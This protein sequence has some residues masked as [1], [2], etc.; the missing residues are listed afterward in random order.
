MSTRIHIVGAP[1]SGTT[2]LAEL[3]VSAFR[4]DAYAPHEMSI[5]K[6]PDR[7]VD[8]FCSKNP[9]DVLYV[10]PLLAIDRGL[11]V[12]YVLRDPRDAIVS[13]HDKAPDLYWSNLRI[14]K[15]YHRA[16][17]RIM[18]H[19]RC[20]V[21]RYE[22]LVRDPDHVQAE[23]IARLPFLQR[24]H[25]FSD[26]HRIV[27]PSDGSLKALRGVRPIDG[28]NVG[29]WRAHKPRVAAQLQL[30]GPIGDELVALGYEADARWLLELADATP[31]TQA[32][33]HS[34]QPKLARRVRV[35]AQHWVGLLRYVFGVR[36]RVPVLP[37]AHPTSGAD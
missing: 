23:L 4:F 32:S 6:R 21:V 13:R 12:I 26:Y 35:C 9:Q 19:P 28:G 16:A 5:F 15:K 2:L 10:R 17:L 22:D 29:A 30:H 31:D 7:A 14:W 34:E 33:Y 18:Q 36:A 8:V 11:W 1:R 25:A 3:M 20:V 37:R 27:R 24:L